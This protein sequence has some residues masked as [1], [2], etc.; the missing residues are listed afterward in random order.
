MKKKLIA[1][2]LV[3]AM[4][5]A[6][7]GMEASAETAK[8]ERVYVV[9]APDGTVLSLTDTIRLE[10]RDLLDEITDS[11]MLS[12][13]VNGEQSFTLNDGV[14]TWEAM[15][16]DITYQGTSDKTPEVLPVVRFMLDG[17]EVSASELAET[18]GD[19]SVE[20]TYSAS[21]EHPALAVTAVILPEKG[22]SGI[23]AE[24]ATVMEEA[25]YRALVGWAVSGV[26]DAGRVSCRPPGVFLDD[27]LCFR[28]PCQLYLQ[29]G[30]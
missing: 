18:E 16:E 22:I 20:V 27:D 11:T 3:L 28:R 19:V 6:L 15:G 8:H 9:A 4:T 10:N 1:V 7:G 21:G 14:L 23:T 17:E 5:L 24:N 2:M 13:N 12:Q 30:R 26:D 25:G 29:R